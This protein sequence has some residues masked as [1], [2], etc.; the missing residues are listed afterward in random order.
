MFVCLAVISIKIKLLLMNA[1][2][3]FIS[4]PFLLFYLSDAY[5]ILYL[6]GIGCCCIMIFKYSCS[7]VAETNSL[8]LS[9]SFCLS[10]LKKR[11]G[12][13][14]TILLSKSYRKK[15]TTIGSTFIIYI[16][17]DGGTSVLSM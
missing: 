17:T 10:S 5:I 7:P 8:L 12:I 4:L 3:T 6:Y 9:S 16:R 11:F 13:R 14:F 1:S 2:L 15:K